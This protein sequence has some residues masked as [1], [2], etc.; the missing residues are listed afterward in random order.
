MAKKKQ[1]RIIKAEPAATPV[2]AGGA[3]DLNILHPE[4][5]V[6]IAGRSVVMR[7]YGF[8]E[9]LKLQPLYQPFVDEL[10]DAV[11]DTGVPALSQIIGLMARHTDSIEQ[12]IAIAAD[13]EVEWVAGLGDRDGSNL[14]YLWWA[15]NAPFFMRRVFDRI[16]ADRAMAHQQGGETSMP[17]SSSTDTSQQPSDATPAAR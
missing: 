1:D 10:H 4:R 14:L 17:S 2:A 16:A 6:T 13:V 3:D 8:I 5:S 15:V 11:V 9:G 7:E 12:L